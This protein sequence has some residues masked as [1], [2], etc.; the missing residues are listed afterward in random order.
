MRRSTEGSLCKA[1][2]KGLPLGRMKVYDLCCYRS[3]YASLLALY[4]F[5]TALRIETSLFRQCPSGQ[6]KRHQNVGMKK[7]PIIEVGNR[8]HWSPSPLRE[9]AKENGSND[10]RAGFRVRNMVKSDTQSRRL[11]VLWEYAAMRPESCILVPLTLLRKNCIAKNGQSLLHQIF[12]AN[13][14]MVISVP[15]VRIHHDGLALMEGM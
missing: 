10:P 3:P 15:N 14:M 5:V 6:K 2:P 4:F 7:A 12:F 11:A 1:P 8:N 9:N 13:A